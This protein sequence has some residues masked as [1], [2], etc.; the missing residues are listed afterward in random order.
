MTSQKRDDNYS[1][2]RQKGDTGGKKI[3]RAEKR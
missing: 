1:Y 2:R 3:G